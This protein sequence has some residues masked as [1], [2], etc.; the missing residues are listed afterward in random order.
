MAKARL[1]HGRLGRM[2]GLVG[3]QGPDCFNVAAYYAALTTR[4]RAMRALAHHLATPDQPEPPSAL[5]GLTW[6]NPHGTCRRPTKLRHEIFV[7]VEVQIDC[8]VLDTPG[9]WK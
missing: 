1:P 2:V 7:A 5:C 4:R 6:Q 8:A 9:F 3:A